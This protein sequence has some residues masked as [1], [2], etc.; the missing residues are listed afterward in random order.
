MLRGLQGRVQK[1]Q[2]EGVE[3]P[4]LPLEL[5]FSLIVYRYNNS[6]KTVSRVVV[7][8]KRFENTRKKGGPRLPWPLP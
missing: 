3:S 8:Q 4:T 1:I 5:H 2:K 6:R 7:V